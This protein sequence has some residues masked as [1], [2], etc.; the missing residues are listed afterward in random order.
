MELAI[1][2]FVLFVGFSIYSIFYIIFVIFRINGELNERYNRYLITE[3]LIQRIRSGEDVP[4]EDFD[5]LL[6]KN[7]YN[8]WQKSECKRNMSLERWKDYMV[9][10]YSDNNKTNIEYIKVLAGQAYVNSMLFGSTH[11]KRKRMK[12]FYFVPEEEIKKLNE[13]DLKLYYD[14]LD[15]CRRYA[16][17]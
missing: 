3:D 5:E 13:N 4:L 8:D 12:E 16:T 11:E 9:E 17:I 1:L 10:Q 2:L 7:K 14:C 6:D 15:S